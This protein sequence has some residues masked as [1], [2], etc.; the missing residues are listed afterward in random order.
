M[1]DEQTQTEPTLSPIEQ[2]LRDT[3]DDS[4]MDS[5]ERDD[6]ISEAIDQEMFEANEAVT[7]PHLSHE[8]RHVEN[9]HLWIFSA[10]ASLQALLWFNF[11]IT[12]AYQGF[13]I[14]SKVGKGILRSIQSESYVFFSDSYHPYRI[15]DINLHAP[16]VASVE[17]YYDADKKI[18]IAAPL[19]EN[20]SDYSPRHFPYLSGEV[21]YNDLTL[22]DISD[23]LNELRWV[24]NGGAPS[25]KHILAAWSL[26]SGIVLL[27]NKDHLTLQ[28]IMDT[29]NEETIRI[30][31]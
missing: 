14:V 26:Y 3:A 18:F 20:S 31:A 30:F 29:G 28:C 25:P 8:Q 5:A 6:I 22:H 11:I 4:D 24:G 23:F 15:Q 13:T 17:W 21:R 12:L 16:G 10:E 19:Y 7:G 2:A 9:P 27:H 1:A